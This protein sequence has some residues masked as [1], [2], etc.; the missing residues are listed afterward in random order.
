MGFNDRA[1]DR[2]AHIQTAGLCRVEGIK[3][4]LKR[5][6]RQARTRISYPEVNAVWLRLPGADKQLSCS[7]VGAAHGLNGI[8]DQV[9]NHLLKLHSIAFDERQA[10]REMQR[11]NLASFDD[12]VGLS[13]QRR[14][15]AEPFNDLEIGQLLEPGMV[16]S[17]A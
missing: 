2:Q 13:K 4:T 1:A 9:E 12:P 14:C 17:S 5:R 3:D 15:G 7:F 16:W 11:S 10:L 6:W 8:P